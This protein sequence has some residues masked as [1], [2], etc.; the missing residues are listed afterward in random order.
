MHWLQ[1]VCIAVHNFKAVH[2]RLS[3]QQI[4][5]DFFTL[6]SPTRQGQVPAPQEQT[7]QAGDTGYMAKLL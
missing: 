6:T 7:E 1:S 2:K 5:T 3:T 4:V